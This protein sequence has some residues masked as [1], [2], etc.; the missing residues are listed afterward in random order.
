MHRD[1]TYELFVKDVSRLGDPIA[2]KGESTTYIRGWKSSP[3]GA[4]LF[5]NCV[6]T[7]R[8]SVIL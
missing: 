3:R 2:A 5:D 8:R 4:W 1:R 7:R 6:Y